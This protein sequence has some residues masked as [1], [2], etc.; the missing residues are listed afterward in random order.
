MKLLNLN[1]PQAMMALVVRR[2][3]WIIIPFL[4]LS[5]AV[6][7]LTFMLPR[8]YVSQSRILI[9]PRAVPTDFV[10]DLVVGTTEQRLSV[11]AQR[12][13]TRD[14]LVKMLRSFQGDLPEYKNLN[15]DDAVAKF[16]KQINL[17]F[18]AD[19]QIANGQLP[20][21]TFDITYQNGNPEVARKIAQNVT[22]LF[23]KQDV[24]TREEN[25]NKT[26]EFLDGQVKELLGQLSESDKKLSDLRSRRRYE[27]P[28]QME[29]NF[30]QV[31]SL[32]SEN[33]NIA[34]QLTF[35]QDALRKLEQQIDA[36]PKEIP[37]A[38]SPANTPTAIVQNQK[39][40]DYRAKQRE[41]KEFKSRG[42]KDNYPP[43]LSLNTQLESLEKEMTPEELAMANG[44]EDKLQVDGTPA[45]DV[46]MIK[47]HAYE[48]LVDQRRT[49][50]LGIEAAQKTQ[51]K[52]ENAIAIAVK[53]I[54]NAPSG[55]QELSEIQRENLDLT[56][57][58]QEMK[59]KLSIAQLSVTSE[60]L[61]Q[62]NQFELVI[63]PSV[64]Q[65]PAKPVKSAIIG[66]GMLASLLLG[67][68]FAFIVDIGNQKMW[69][70]AD[71]EALLGA[72]VLV[73]IPEI[74]TPDDL[75]AARKKRTNRIASLAAA[76]AVYAVCLYFVYIHGPFV[77][78]HL[79]PLL[80]RLY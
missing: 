77:L 35:A 18:G 47:N 26:A 8:M 28:S 16:G 78:Q 20:V 62:G 48:L 30:Q 6:T 67:L 29:A 23:I 64:P 65:T 7:L 69:T 19:Q 76:A 58:Y 25:V 11:I 59:D 75:I 13:L 52:N 50:Q 60:G 38:S 37:K 43:V 57:R 51:Q 39:I 68:A 66:G 53:H 41:L 74:V 61:Q 1:G 21:T 49:L 79:D 32:R 22:D 24:D 4:G 17:K 15:M 46:E 70:H 34:T 10:K 3:W 80:Q 27:L 33:Q 12:V 73:E 5:A 9:K 14:N 42:Y 45:P 63:T 56:R 40:A 31:T 71:I 2:K 44:K 72:T 54:E 55:E 36:T